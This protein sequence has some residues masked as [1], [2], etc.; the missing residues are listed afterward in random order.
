MLF[1]QCENQLN[2]ILIYIYFNCYTVRLFKY[3][4]AMLRQYVVY[5]VQIGPF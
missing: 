4:I 2:D 5:R 3:F 1:R